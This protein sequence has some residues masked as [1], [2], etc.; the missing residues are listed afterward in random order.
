MWEFRTF[1]FILLLYF[2]CLCFNK[3]F[4]LFDTLAHWKSRS[5]QRVVI[6]AIYIYIYIYI[7]LR[8]HSARTCLLKPLKP[9]TTTTSELKNHVKKEGNPYVKCVSVN[10]SVLMLVSVRSCQND[11]SNQRNGSFGISVRLSSGGSVGSV[12]CVLCVCGG[13]GV[14]VPFCIFL[15]PLLLLSLIHT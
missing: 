8:V 2:G 11:N 14:G 6:W 3:L 10:V 13:D 4:S 15:F 7:Y 9:T 1:S 12:C 5:P